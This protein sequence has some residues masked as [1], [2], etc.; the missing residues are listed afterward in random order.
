M[1]SKIVFAALS[2]AIVLNGAS[3]AFAGGKKGL[4]D[5]R[6]TVTSAKKS[7]GGGQAWCDID[8]NCNGWNEWLQG[9]QAGK[10]YN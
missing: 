4:V 2:L 1:N 5:P 3:A 10:K 8:P 9:V 6:T 7:K